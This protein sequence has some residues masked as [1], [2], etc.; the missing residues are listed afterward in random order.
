MLQR[1]TLTGLFF[2]LGIG[3][4]SPTMLLGASLGII[5]ALLTVQFLRFN[6][7]EVNDGSYGFNAALVGMAIFY[8]LPPTLFSLALTIFAGAFSTVV[9][10]FWLLK[11][12]ELPVFTAPF[13]ITTWLLLLLIEALAVNIEIP[14]FTDKTQGDFYLIMRGI[15]QVMFQSNWFCGVI[16]ITGLLLH[17]M[18]VATW[19]VIG[20]TAGLLIARALNFP[21]DIII[22]GV[23]GFNASLTAVALSSRC[24]QKLWSILLGITLAVLLTGVFEYL[25][26][27]ALTA[28]FVLASWSVIA[29]IKAS[30]KNATELQKSAGG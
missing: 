24:N 14:P 22:M 13:V 5:S 8:F 21:S 17:S 6:T 11:F 3:I 27:P 26:I 7:N 1:S 4:N 18:K 15:A 2:A 9:M 12:V 19:A 20:S 25:S 16:F 30:D 10:R 23:Y 29:L 28:P